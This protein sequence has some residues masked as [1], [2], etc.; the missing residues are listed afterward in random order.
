MIRHINKHTWVR[1]RSKRDHIIKHLD[2]EYNRNAREK[3]LSLT[4]TRTNAW[5]HQLD[6]YI[7]ALADLPRDQA[8]THPRD[9]IWPTKPE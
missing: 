2:W 9:I 1:I 4:P 5:M 8:G 6:L 7:Q 3:R